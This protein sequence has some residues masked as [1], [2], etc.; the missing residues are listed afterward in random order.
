MR[1]RA[2]VCRK[3]HPLT[4]DNLMVQGSSRRCRI[5]YKAGQEVCKARDREKYKMKVQADVDAANARKRAALAAPRPMLNG[6]P[7]FNPARANSHGNGMEV[8]DF[9]G[10]T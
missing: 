4:D 3:G 8:L 7:F 10:L 5:C 2:T 6:A 9:Y 1:P